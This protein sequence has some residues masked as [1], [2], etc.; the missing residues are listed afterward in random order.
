ML[1][2]VTVQQIDNCKTVVSVITKR[3]LV[4]NITAKGDY[5]TSIFK[6]IE[7]KLLEIIMSKISG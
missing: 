7:L 3:K 1:V 6:N 4:T 5:S 2:R